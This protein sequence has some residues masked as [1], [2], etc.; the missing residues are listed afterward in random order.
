MAMPKI[1]IYNID[2]IRF[3]VT[4]CYFDDKE[5]GIK[6]NIA[7]NTSIDNTNKL[8]VIQLDVK[9][10]ISSGDAEEFRQVGHIE[11]EHVFH[12]EEW[13]EYV[14]TEDKTFVVEQE[15]EH[16]LMNIAYND[17]RGILLSKAAGTL[18]GKLY[19]PIIDPADISRTNSL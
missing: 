5:I 8:L 11:T 2:T 19:L 17:T 10:R 18:L 13:D 3:N 4:D 14:K 6:L 16:L 12:I 15:L 9:I 1:T 7:S